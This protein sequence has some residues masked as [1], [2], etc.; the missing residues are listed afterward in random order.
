MEMKL[1]SVYDKVSG[2][3]SAPFACSNQ[4]VAVRQFYYAMSQA[5]MVARDSSLYELGTF[6]TVTGVIKFN[7]VQFVCN[8]EVQS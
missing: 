3:Y 5:A 6:D 1:F 7:E 4:A 8:Y 2:L